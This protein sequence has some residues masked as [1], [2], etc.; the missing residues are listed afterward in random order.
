MQKVGRERKR[1]IGKGG[2][3]NSKIVEKVYRKN[4]RDCVNSVLVVFC[5]DSL[6]NRCT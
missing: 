6:S 3:T 5:S 2:I 1:A 4:A